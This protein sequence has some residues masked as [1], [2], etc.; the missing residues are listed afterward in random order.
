[1]MERGGGGEA[2]GDEEG[3]GDEV[4]GG[5]GGWVMEMEEVRGM[6]V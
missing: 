3:E 1:M 4:R 6:E 2:R 5:G